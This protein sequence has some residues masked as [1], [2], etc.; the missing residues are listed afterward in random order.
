MKEHFNTKRDFYLSI[1]HHIISIYHSVQ[2]NHFDSPIN[3]SVPR[4]VFICTW[5]MTWSAGHIYSI[6]SAKFENIY[7][8]KCI[9]ATYSGG[10]CWHHKGEALKRQE[11]A[12]LSPSPGSLPPTHPPHWL[13]AMRPLKCRRRSLDKLVQNQLVLTALL[14]TSWRITLVLFPNVTRGDFT[15]CLSHRGRWCLGS[16]PRKKIEALHFPGKSKQLNFILLQLKWQAS[17]L[18]H[19]TL[20]FS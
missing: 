5:N 16:L 1:T 17:R 10:W 20:M 15:L 9:I 12:A 14:G 3:L 19:F 18:S 11:S 8:V 2:K 13:M 6:D 4:N 7:S